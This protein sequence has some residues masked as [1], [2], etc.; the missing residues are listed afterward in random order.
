MAES[1]EFDE[2]TKATPG[3][4][5]GVHNLQV[6]AERRLSPRCPSE[7]PM[8]YRY[9]RAAGPGRWVSSWTGN[10]S[11]SGLCFP[12]ASA[13]EFLRQAVGPHAPRVEVELDLPGCGE[14]IRCLAKV[15]WAHVTED[16]GGA[17]EIGV[18]LLDLPEAAQERLERFVQRRLPA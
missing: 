11:C 8:R 4:R 18:R 16:G 3:V 6:G 13:G 1:A 12:A 5:R 15:V 9:L 14:L 17:D 7:L 10:I 2:P